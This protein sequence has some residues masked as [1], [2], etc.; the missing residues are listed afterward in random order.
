MATELTTKDLRRRNRSRV[1]R[2]LIRDGET[3]RNRIASSLGLSLGTVT[4]VISDLVAEGLLQESGMLPS[5]GGRPTASLSVNPTGA[6]F[7]GASVREDGVTVGVL[8]LSMRVV[9]RVHNGSPQFSGPEEMGAALAKSI[10]QAIDEAGKPANIYGIG[11]GMPGIIQANGFTSSGSVDY[12]MTSYGYGQGLD[13]AR[14]PNS[15]ETIYRH[16][17]LPIFADNGAKTQAMAEAWFGAARDMDD[18]LIALVGRGVGLGIISDGHLLR[19]SVMA[20]GEWGH[21]KIA[22]NGLACSCGSSG[23]LG[24]YIGGTGIARRWSEAGGKP[25][26][27]VETALVALIEAAKSGDSVA[28]GILDET[29]ELLGL[30]LSNL[31]NLFNPERIV[32]GGWVGLS[33]AEYGID[34]IAEATK[35]RSLPHLASEFDFVPAS[36]G[37]DSTALGAALLAVESLIDA[38]IDNTA[39][40]PDEPIWD[41]T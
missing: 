37:R 13:W 19:G 8:D 5:S 3:T 38:P 31:V 30:G 15:L 12:V 36:L 7:V 33:L 4:N 27:D 16:P 40:A 21:T 9:S 17:D 35:S 11:L 34:R 41:R 6:H 29:I 28:T 1:L 14:T 23:C 39:L 32:L 10:D 25:P 22:L 26:V 2:V 20:A 24:T 18:V